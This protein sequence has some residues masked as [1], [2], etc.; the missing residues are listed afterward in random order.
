[1]SFIVKVVIVVAVVV[2]LVCVE[3][4]LSQTFV[5]VAV[6]QSLTCK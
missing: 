4:H 1:M 3:R 6:T 2:V 5:R